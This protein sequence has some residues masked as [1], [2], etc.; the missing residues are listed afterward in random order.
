[1][2]VQSVQEFNLL[3]AVTSTGAGDAFG[4]SS[5]KGVAIFLK[6]TGAGTLKIQTNVGGEWFDI[7]EEIFGGAG[8]K[9]L[10]QNNGAYKSI[11]AN[12]TARSS[13]AF[14]AWMQGSIEGI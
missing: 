9:V 8:T 2:A 13:G 6:A 12:L 11:R 7:H 14:S 4:V 3:N 10:Y 1:M 5:M